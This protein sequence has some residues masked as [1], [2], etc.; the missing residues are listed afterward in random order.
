MELVLVYA[1]TLAILLA[2]IP[3][4]WADVTVENHQMYVGDDG[5]L[6][7][8]GELANEISA[9][10]RHAKITVDVYSEDNRLLESQSSTTLV[11]TIMPETRS[12]FD[13]V[14]S[15][16]AEAAH[17]YEISAEYE[18]GDPKSQAIDIT[19]SE[20]AVDS[21]GNLLVSGTVVNR[22]DITAN[23]V[24]VTATL[25][26][27]GGDVVAVSQVYIEP[28]YLR[29]GDEAR[30]VVPVLDRSRADLV[31]GYSLA[32]ESDEYAPVPEFSAGP[33]LLLAGSVGGFILIS[34]FRYGIITGSISAADPA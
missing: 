3:Y 13:L 17:S 22:G 32:A 26:D 28:D 16:G 34:R 4:A 23:A 10:I 12:P 27:R 18:I 6:H 19:E 8:V 15:G 14:L 29:A 9:P 24:F 30:F 25:Y 20:L 11:R 21:V 2:A 33:A 31:A 1:A 7:I 5:I